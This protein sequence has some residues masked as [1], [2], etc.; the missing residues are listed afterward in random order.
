[1][2]GSPS[3]PSAPSAAAN[4]GSIGARSSTDGTFHGSDE[5]ARKVSESRITGVRYLIAIDAASNA[6]SKQP[7]GVLGA[8]TGSGDSP[9]RPYIAIS[10][11]D[12]S[13]LVGMPVDGP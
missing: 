13:V 12:C 3:A 11:S 2:N 1:M 6:A 7:P 4:A 10:R 8:I 9:W 5:E